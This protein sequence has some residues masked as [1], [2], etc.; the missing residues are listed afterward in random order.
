M[1]H[2][3]EKNRKARQDSL[4]EWLSEKCTAQHLVN[5]INKI[6]NLDP[7]CESFSNELAKLKTANEQRLKILDKYLPNLKA[8]EHTGDGGQDL[9]TKIVIE[10]VE[11]VHAQYQDTE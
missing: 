4:R 1:R 11:S 10:A 8:I 6:E 2:V 3:A 5:N 9:V 7:E